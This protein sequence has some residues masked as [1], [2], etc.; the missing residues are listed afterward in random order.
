MFSQ[1]GLSCPRSSGWHR[2]QDQVAGCGAARARGRTPEGVDKR[3]CSGD[4]QGGPHTGAR[5][6]VRGPCGGGSESG[7]QRTDETCK[8]Q[9]EGKPDLDDVRRTSSGSKI[10]SRRML[11]P[12]SSRGLHNGRTTWSSARRNWTSMVEQIT[13]GSKKLKQGFETHAENLKDLMA[14][15]CRAGV[16]RLSES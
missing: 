4:R 12:K 2:R 10:D 6:D 16:A 13:V 11:R 14:Q 7:E 5:R 15:S 8:S 9:T 1:L 3:V